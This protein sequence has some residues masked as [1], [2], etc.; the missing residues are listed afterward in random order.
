MPER[1]F[2]P[3]SAAYTCV[4]SMCSEDSLKRLQYAADFSAL[5]VATRGISMGLVITKEAHDG[6]YWL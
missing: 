6:L 1:C 5:H 2:A 4:T 3:A